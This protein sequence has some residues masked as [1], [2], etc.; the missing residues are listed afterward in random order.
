MR[1]LTLVGLGVLL[2]LALVA[3]AQ[4]VACNGTPLSNGCLFTITG[5]DT[6]DPDDGFAV[7]NDGGIP[8][9]DFFKSQNLQS[10]GYP[11]SQ[12]FLFNGFTVQAF[13][14]VMLQW[15]PDKGD[16][17]DYLNT[18]D[19]VANQY[20]LDLANV[21]QHRTLPA[22]D[23][24]S[25]SQIVDNHL[26]LLDQNP[27]IKAAFLAESDWLNLFGL[28]INYD[29]R[30]VSG[31]PQG[32]QL[33]RAQRIVFEIWN[34]PAPG[35]T[36]G[37]VGRQNVPDKV[38]KLSNVIIPN[39]AKAPVTS[40]QAGGPVAE[41]PPAPSPVA[42]PAPTPVPTPAATP[43]PSGAVPA[44]RV[45]AQGLQGYG[46]QG[47]FRR[48][49]DSALGDLAVDAGLNWVKQQ[50]PWQEVENQPNIYNWAFLDKFVN[51]MNG[52]GLNI[53]LSVVKAPDFY[54]AEESKKGTTHGRP[55]DPTTLRTFMKAIASRYQG[56]VQAY[57]IWNEENLSLEWG[58]FSNASYGEFVELMK[59]G[60]IGTKEGDPDA[61]VILG[62]PTPTGVL[63]NTIGIDDAFYLG[64]VFDHNGGE[65][66]NYF[67]ALGV[68]PNGGPN[69]PDDTQANPA[70]SNA[71][72]NGGWSNHPS[73]FFDRYKELYNLMQARGH[74]DKTVWFTEFG[75]AVNDPPV[76]N[77][78]YSRCN[79]EQDQANF[80]TRAF[81]K[82]RAES[83][84]VTH[85]IIWNLNFQEVVP[86]TD[87]KWAFGI[88][89]SD[90]SPRPAFTAI[91]N[92]IK[93]QPAG[94]PS[95]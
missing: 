4:A 85:M 92:M 77:Y 70:H 3:P 61:V 28:P 19:I 27:K 57:E 75:W 74:G 63:S 90:L 37:A 36:L 69:A 9:W 60:Y 51:T 39:A 23:G 80:F 95:G 91:K 68:H 15:R 31:N 35:T 66:F 56:R 24:A 10:V 87:E 18:L 17:F 33:L 8:F 54:K 78:E 25:F 6:S 58:T 76:T 46:I 62:A 13:Q 89:R 42:T 20:G 7:T 26:A 49:N 41:A 72:C 34:V 83:A 22:D 93:P 94:S 71:T 14:K 5:G 2:S 79:T 38:K 11:I 84:Y 21:P 67:E 43:T 81:E 64:K 82:V 86:Q 65:V 48:A 29:E 16:R 88:V 44:P 50:V 12:R 53:L 59:Q 1:K 45:L 32:L 52:K 55:G 30:E 73:F 40:A 47:E